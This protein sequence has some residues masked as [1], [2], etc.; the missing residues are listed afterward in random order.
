MD[1]Q[2]AAKDACCMVGQVLAGALVLRPGDMPDFTMLV[3]MNT[4]KQAD[5]EQDPRRHRGSGRGGERL[6]DVEW[7]LLLQASGTKGNTRYLTCC[8]SETQPG[9]ERW[10]HLSPGVLGWCISGEE[11]SLILLEG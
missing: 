5:E 7:V 8:P 6:H 11:S 10:V 9:R 4:Q 1:L 2:Y 3:S